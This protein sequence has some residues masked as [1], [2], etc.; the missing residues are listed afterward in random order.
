MTDCHLSSLILNRSEEEMLILLKRAPLSFTD[1]G[2]TIF[3][4]IASG[5]LGLILV[6]SKTT[7]DGLLAYCG[8]DC[9]TYKRI[10]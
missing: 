5:G 3:K 10:I 1:N 7:L 2:F 4:K 8:M 9:K 6:T